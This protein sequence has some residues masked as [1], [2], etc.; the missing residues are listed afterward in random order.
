[1]SRCQRGFTLIELLVVIAII[2]LLMGILLPAL[3][4]A[5]KQAQATMCLSGL[6][7]IGVAANLYAQD[8][9]S[10]IVRGSTGSTPIWFMQYLPYLGQRYNTGAYR[11]VKAYHCAS[12][13]TTG[14]GLYDL[15][16][17]A[18]TVCYVM[19]DWTFAGRTDDAGT[20]VGKPTKLS[21]FQRPAQTIY[22]ADN[23]DGSWRPIIETETSREVFRCDIFVET[24]LPLSDSE[25]I[26]NGRRIARA[27]HKKGCNVLLLDWHSEYVAAE[28]MTLDMW[29][30]KQ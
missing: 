3:A 6:Q 29:R 8:N 17:S 12:F 28:D 19:N 13:P 16:N 11:S 20:S 9:D 5:K 10:F 2:A 7:Q 18:Q 15:P 24:H 23:E 4:K 22:L 26:N 25:D 21:V 1:M 27:R 30:D 14:L